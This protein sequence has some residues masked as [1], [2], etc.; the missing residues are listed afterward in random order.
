MRIIL[1]CDI[2]NVEVDL[3]MNYVKYKHITKFNLFIS[4]FIFVLIS[5]LVYF[6]VFLLEKQN[7]NYQ[8]TAE[9]IILL[10]RGDQLYLSPPKI[11]SNQI[12]LKKYNYFGYED[13]NGEYYLSTCFTNKVISAE[14]QDYI[15]RANTFG[16][17]SEGTYQIT[18]ISYLIQYPKNNESFYINEDNYLIF[19]YEND[20]YMVGVSSQTDIIALFDIDKP[21]I[22]I[23][24][25]KIINALFETS[26]NLLVFE[27]EILTIEVDDTKG[28]YVYFGDISYQSHYQLNEEIEILTYL[29]MEEVGTGTIDLNKSHIAISFTTA[30][31]ETV[32]YAKVYLRYNSSNVLEDNIFYNEISWKYTIKLVEN[33][34]Y[35]FTY[36]IYDD[37][38][39][40]T[41]ETFEFVCG[42]ITKPTIKIEDGFLNKTTFTRYDILHFDKSKLILQDNQTA[43]DYLYNELQIKIVNLVN[44]AEINA[45]CYGNYS[46]DML[47]DYEIVLNTVD[48]AKNFSEQSIQFKVIQ[49]NL[50]E[51]IEIEFNNNGTSVPLNLMIYNGEK[52]TFDVEINGIMLEENI[53]YFVTIMKNGNITN[54][55]KNAGNYDLILYNDTSSIVEE[56]IVQKANFNLEGV[57]IKNLIQTYNGQ[58]KSVL[59]K[60]DLP[61]NTDIEYKYYLNNIETQPV[62]TG[63]Y[64]VLIKLQNENYNDEILQYNLIIKANLDNNFDFVIY[65]ILLAFIFVISISFYFLNKNK[66]R[67]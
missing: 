65:F 66:T 52:F 59:L 64:L 37:C 63:A 6:F 33:A 53:D 13:I 29:S 27:G 3:L 47:G 56:I 18:Q 8:A 7:Q 41:S 10:E 62:E 4:F 15:L 23:S 42:D 9:N 39:N 26:A 30:N 16:A 34:K 61:L 44:G 2:F 1:L 38:N 57:E 60:G 22:E 12:D 28:P 11:D 31:G 58:E 19:T 36:N 51:G 35:H 20:Q 55:I 45:D 14:N 17:R 32:D 5:F 54:E 43:S 48:E 25:E 46:F 24:E 49:P 40:V 67:Y 50:S 21:Y